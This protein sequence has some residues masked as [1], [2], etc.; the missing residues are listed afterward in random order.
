V[1][2]DRQQVRD[3]ALARLSKKIKRAK[4]LAKRDEERCRIGAIVNIDGKQ[5]RVVA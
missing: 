5:Y 3:R 4:K 1:A 2:N